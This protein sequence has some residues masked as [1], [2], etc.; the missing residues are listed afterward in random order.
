MFLNVPS[1][2][3]FAATDF[4]APIR[5]LNY[6]HSTT[7]VVRG[8]RHESTRSHKMSAEHESGGRFFDAFYETDSEHEADLYGAYSH[9]I[10]LL[11]DADETEA[12]SFEAPLRRRTESTAPVSAP[13]TDW[14]RQGIVLDTV[15][16][17]VTATVGIA[18]NAVHASSLSCADLVDY[19]VTHAVVRAM[20]DLAMYA[21]HEAFE[22][23]LLMM[24]LS[25]LVTYPTP[26][27]PEHAAVTDM[28]SRLSSVFDKQ[29]LPSS[30]STTRLSGGSPSPVPDAP[31]THAVAHSRILHKFSLLDSGGLFKGER[32]EDS[33]LRLPQSLDDV[34]KCLETRAYASDMDFELDLRC[35]FLGGMM[36]HEAG[37]AGWT[38]SRRL[39]HAVSGCLE[40][41]GVAALCTAAARHDAAEA[42]APPQ[43]LP[44]AEDDVC[45]ALLSKLAALDTRLLFAAPV[46]RVPRYR[47]V[48]RC[49]LLSGYRIMRE[50]HTGYPSSDGHH[51]TQPE[52][53][54]RPL[55]Q[56]AHL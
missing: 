56:H 27:A 21:S 6:C 30:V 16:Q 52:A 51:D 32:D 23:D 4:A 31:R 50:T 28:L 35:L 33:G 37:S 22:A 42:A 29:Q 38:E 40:Q 2:L 26:A 34:K 17:K 15:F 55:P 13:L 43:K 53:P 14:S 49:L 18:S 44:Q 12:F 7:G 46:E 19:N 54:L 11:T 48:R 8:L 45:Q 3:S 24:L 39:L 41:A 47:Q 1:V 5:G 20:L 9:D 25:W 10:T 36:K